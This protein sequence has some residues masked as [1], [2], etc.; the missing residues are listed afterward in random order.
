MLEKSH[1]VLKEL[2]LRLPIVIERIVDDGC[3]E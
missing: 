1:A 2:C 3:F